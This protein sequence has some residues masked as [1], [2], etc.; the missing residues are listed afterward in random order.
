MVNKLIHSLEI[1]EC[2]DLAHEVLNYVSSEKIENR[3][4]QWVKDRAY[5]VYEFFHLFK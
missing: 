4:N 1:K 5:E 3:I 2:E